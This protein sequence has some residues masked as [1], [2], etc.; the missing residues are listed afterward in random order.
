MP[1]NTLSMGFSMESVRNAFSLSYVE[2]REKF[3]AATHAAGLAVQ[4]HLNSNRGV[5]GETLAIDVVRDGPMDAPNVLF[6]SSACHGV[7]GYCGSGVQVHALGDGTWLK[8]A[9]RAG[10]AVVYVHAMNPYGFSH[11]RRV[12]ED[13]VDLNRNFH[14]FDAPLPVNLAYRGVHALLLPD[15][16]PPTPATQAALQQYIATHGMPA[17]QAAA[18]GGQHEFP[19]GV[20]YGGVRETWSNTTIRK[21][22]REH[23]GSARRIGWID[24][25]TGLGPSG[26][27]ERIFG[28]PNSAADVARAQAWWGGE[29]RTPVTSMYD[30]SSSSAPLTGVLGHAREKEC[31]QAEFTCLAM[32]Y[33]TQPVMQ[34]MQALRADHWLHAHPDAAPRLAVTVKR[35]MLAAF[36]TDTDEWKMQVVEQAQEAMR[37]AVTGLL[38]PA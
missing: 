10:L 24:L 19:D 33:G 29:G 22:M 21:V 16:W 30:G 4:S 13:N 11:K 28:G 9:R 32:E 17:F 7:E 35:D 23:G 6:I 15:Q 12:T 27:G 8:Q 34:V 20:F 31:P 36:Y 3:L 1:E 38:S 5:A 26:H 14:D 2:A 25:H 18:S 37:Q